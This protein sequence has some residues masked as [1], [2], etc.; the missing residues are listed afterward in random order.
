ME[1]KALIIVFS[2]ISKKKLIMLNKKQEESNIIQCVFSKTCQDGN[3][4]QSAKK[5]GMDI[6]NLKITNHSSRS[7]IV[8][9][10]V[11]L[12]RISETRSHKNNLTLKPYFVTLI[13]AE[14]LYVTKYDFYRRTFFC[15]Q[16]K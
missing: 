5:C 13:I 7:T 11:K 3:K 6:Q 16:N 2:T 4:K 14:L 1:K 10:I 8:S 12:S 15:L 9:Y